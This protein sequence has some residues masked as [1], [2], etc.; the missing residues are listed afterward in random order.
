MHYNITLVIMQ[1]Y[2]YFFVY[3]LYYI[4]VHQEEHKDIGKSIPRRAQNN[5]IPKTQIRKEHQKVKQQG[6]P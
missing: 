4:Y 1:I 6:I 5:E 2:C 3:H